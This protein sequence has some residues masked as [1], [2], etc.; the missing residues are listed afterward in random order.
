M[1]ENYSFRA[2]TAYASRK[3]PLFISG[4]FIHSHKEKDLLYSSMMNEKMLLKKLRSLFAP[5]FVIRVGRRTGTLM[6]TQA[7]YQKHKESARALVHRKIEEHNAHYGFI[8]GTIAIRNQRTR[9]GSC[10]KK[11]NLNFHYR[12]TL[13][14]EHLADYLVVHELCHLSEFNHSK[15]FWD[16][17]SEKIPDYKARRKAL[18]SHALQT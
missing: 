18:K 2:A 11:G 12:I 16:L 3:P 13:L 10:S 5:R 8:F 14:P 9:W 4:F 17:V 6:G 7:A 1:E 15:K